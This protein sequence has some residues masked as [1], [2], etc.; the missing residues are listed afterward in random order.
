MAFLAF[1]NSKF[2]NRIAWPSRPK[3]R[4]LL[5]QKEYESHEAYYLQKNIKYNIQEGHGIVPDE[6]SWWLNGHLLCNTADAWSERSLNELRNMLTSIFDPWTFKPMAFFINRRDA[7]LL[8]KSA[9][10]SPHW[11]ALGPVPE[12]PLFYGLDTKTAVYSYYGSHENKDILWPPPEHWNLDLTW[13]EWP[14]KPLAVFRGSLTGRHSD[15]RNIRLQ[16]VRLASKIPGLLD[17]G[18]TAWTPRCRVETIY[19]S[20]FVV[21]NGRPADIQL[22]KPL[23]MQDQA[24]HA[25]I[26][27]V[28]GHSASMRL[29][30]HYLSGSCVVKI[31]DPT[32]AAPDQWFDS[33]EH[34]EYR[35]EVNKHYLET[36]I[37]GLEALL[38]ELF[39]RVGLLKAQTI[40]LAAQQV[41]RRVFDHQFMR[42]HVRQSVMRHAQ[43]C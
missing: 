35:F 11:A 1:S 37:D 17:A 29:A 42:A 3:L 40:G 24:R 33:F 9:T 6:T 8:M 18:L 26:I 13:P 15:D 10:M 16:L 38:E 28:P 4:F 31:R 25:V 32:C 12:A 21:Y 5:D 43:Y 34:S 36:T 19:K 20:T 23:T 22:V 2:D 7:P 30:W 14:K 39:S 41:A 27:Y